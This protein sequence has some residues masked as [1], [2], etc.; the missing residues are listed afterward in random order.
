MFEQPGQSAEVA[1]FCAPHTLDIWTGFRAGK[2]KCDAAVR[3]VAGDVL[4]A[5]LARLGL[6]GSPFNHAP[7]WGGIQLGAAHGAQGAGMAFSMAHPG[8]DSERWTFPAR[9]LAQMVLKPALETSTRSQRWMMLDGY[10]GSPY[11]G[12]SWK[13]GLEAVP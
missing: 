12:G 11:E 7:N 2:A 10:E 8:G 5:D 4:G 6:L 1:A 13:F 3:H 9:G